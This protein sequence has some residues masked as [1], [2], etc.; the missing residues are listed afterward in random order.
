MVDENWGDGDQHVRV[1][2]H[3]WIHDANFNSHRQ[4]QI[5]ILLTLV[6]G[7]RFLFFSYERIRLVLYNIRVTAI[8]VLMT[9]CCLLRSFWMYLVYVLRRATRCP[10]RFLSLSMEP[11]LS[12][13]RP[14]LFPVYIL[15]SSFV[16]DWGQ[17]N[18]E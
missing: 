2:L 15:R 13:F 11:F 18:E 14:R 10:L 8:S 4:M 12:C 5:S 7:F 17:K 1:E 6:F 9:A 16:L 3:Y